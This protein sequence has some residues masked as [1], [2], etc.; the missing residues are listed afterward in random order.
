M[1]QISAYLLYIIVVASAFFCGSCK[2]HD[3]AEEFYPG[4]AGYPVDRT[5]IIYMVGENSLSST[6]WDDNGNKTTLFLQDAAEIEAVM[7]FIPA[8]ARV[9]LY[10]DGLS[11]SCISAGDFFTPLQQVLTYPYNVPSTDSLGMLT[12]LSDIM[13]LYPS[14]HYGLVLWSHGSG[15]LFPKDEDSPA[16]AP[17]RSFGVDNGHRSTSNDGVKMSI[18]TLKHVLQQLPRL[19]FLFFDACYMQCI[20][21]AYELRRVADYIIGSPAEIPGS[22]APY[23]C[24]TPLLC[25][26][27]AD[28]TGTINAYV[29]FYTNNATYAGAELSLIRT[30]ALDSLAE[31]TRPIVEQLYGGRN[32]PNCYSVQSYTPFSRWNTY[33]ESYDMMNLIYQNVSEDD[34]N[35][36]LEAFRRAVPYSRLSPQWTTS[37]SN[38]PMY[39]SD[40]GHCGGVTL[41]VPSSR[42]EQL[43]WVDIYRQLE[44]YEASGMNQ[45]G[46]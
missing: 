5:I 21:V 17:R 8:N 1:K 35:T 40:A 23:D 10:Q 22:G 16:N 9:V 41:F 29:D 19:D 28:L 18:T 11:S 14:N 30:A 24:V 20:E 36:W 27:P 12:I 32:T 7:P 4:R 33:T 31:A 6:F 34:Y 43:G 25:A 45:T 15:W 42:N 26:S 3:D 13:R 44:W 2:H 38:W 39:L 46:W 37:A